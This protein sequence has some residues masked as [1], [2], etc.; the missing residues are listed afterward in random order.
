[1]NRSKRIIA[2]IILWTFFIQILTPNVLADA[3]FKLYDAYT[4]LSGRLFRKYPDTKPE[5]SGHLVDK[6]DFTIMSAQI[7]YIG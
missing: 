5:T 2:F 4:G 6:F 1:M 3:N 7:Q